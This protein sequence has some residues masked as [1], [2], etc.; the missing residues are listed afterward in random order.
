[1]AQRGLLG[2]GA[3]VG[4]VNIRQPLHTPLLASWAARHRALP[5]WRDVVDMG[6]DGDHRLLF[7]LARFLVHLPHTCTRKRAADRLEW[8]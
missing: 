4:P 7:R 8:A 5:E 6:P 1:M 3:T 2:Q